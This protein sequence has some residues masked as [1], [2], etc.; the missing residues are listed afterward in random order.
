MKKSLVIF[1]SI[2][3]PVLLIC[4]SAG[5]VNTGTTTIANPASTNCINRGGILVIEKRG[6]GGEFGICLFKDNRQCEEWAL[7]RGECPAGGIDITGYATP[8]ARYCA[9]TGGTYDITG[10]AGTDKEQGSCLFRSNICDAWEYYNGKCR[11]KE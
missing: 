4:F 8:A 2:L 6:D 10:E 5:C 11:Q 7:F 3:L 1:I 9:I